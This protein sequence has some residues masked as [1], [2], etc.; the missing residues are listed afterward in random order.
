MRGA[1]RLSPFF[2]SQVNNSCIRKKINKPPEDGCKKITSRKYPRS[3]SNAY[4]KYARRAVRCCSNKRFFFQYTFFPF[5]YYII[6][7]Y[8]LPSYILL[9]TTIYYIVYCT[10][11]YY[12][13]FFLLLFTTNTFTRPPSVVY[14]L[15][16]SMCACEY[17]AIQHSCPVSS[18]QRREFF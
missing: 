7:L 15:Q 3:I 18:L 5:T 14:E 12:Y 2:P 8:R 4:S 6:F 13:Y 10:C 16:C 1:C 11:T 9:Y 17:A